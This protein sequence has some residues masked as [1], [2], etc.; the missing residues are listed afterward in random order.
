MINRADIPPHRDLIVAVQAQVKELVD[1][2]KS[3]QDVLSA[4]PTASYDASVEGGTTPR[5]GGGTSADRF[6]STMYAEFK[7][8]EG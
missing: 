4:R 6:V 7:T 2:G 3:L 8:R 1:Q 5:P